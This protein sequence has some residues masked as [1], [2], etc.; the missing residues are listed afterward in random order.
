MERINMEELVMKLFGRT[1]KKNIIADKM[2]ADLEYDSSRRVVIMYYSD[3]KR[4]IRK[5]FDMNEWLGL[6]VRA[7]TLTQSL[8][9]EAIILQ[10]RVPTWKM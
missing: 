2:Q 9:Q 5:E 7:E 1:G 4:V 8:A 3:S 6:M 10:S